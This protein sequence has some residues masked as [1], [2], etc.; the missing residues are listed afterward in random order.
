MD[1]PMKNVHFA[2]MSLIFK[3]RDW[4]RPPEKVLAEVNIQKGF[5]V[6]D[7]GCGPGVFS[8]AAARRVG[9][10]GR[11]FAL[12]IHPK[13]IQ[14]V[15]DRAAKEGF[16]NIVTILADRPA[17]IEP[18]SID[19]VLLYDIFHMLSG[20]GEVLKGLHRVMKPN[21]LLS[22]S[23]H[24]MKEEQILSRMTADN[25]FVLKH[26]GKRTYSFVKK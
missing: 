14:T 20:S 22:F 25:L 7:Y 2:G 24:H 17:E 3:V 26:R 12:D 5:H 21:S 23:D 6:L 8:I 15:K 9:A 18:E 10:S 16:N 1:R 13:A 11:V 19:I 4:V